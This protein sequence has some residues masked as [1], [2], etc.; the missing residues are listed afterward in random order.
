MRRNSPMTRLQLF[1][2]M[3]AVDTRGEHKGPQGKLR[4][5]ARRSGTEG[6]KLGSD[7]EGRA[8]F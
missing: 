3:G 2:S 5:T 8:D 6:T 7:P 4:A 1:L